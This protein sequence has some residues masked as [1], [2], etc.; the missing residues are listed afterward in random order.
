LLDLAGAEIP[1][2]VEGHPIYSRRNEFVYGD[3]L[4]NN[5]STR[6]VV[7]GRHKIIWYPAGNRLQMFDLQTDPNELKD[8]ANDSQYAA[9][10]ERLIG[11]LC[12]RAWGIDL[13]QQWIKDGKLVGYDPGD[14]V[15]RPDRTWSGQR[16][17]HFP[18]PPPLAQDKMV[19]FPQ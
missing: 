6:M 15:V 4:E 19:G 8:V 2:T 7:D 3:C 1:A 12:R 18:A 13:E 10:R 11:E 9:A 5:G 14:F 17:L 16:G